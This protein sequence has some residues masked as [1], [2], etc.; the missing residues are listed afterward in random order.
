MADVDIDVVDGLGMDQTVRFDRR[1]FP[2]AIRATS[3]S[4]MVIT[5]ISHLGPNR[6]RRLRIIGHASAGL[7]GVADSRTT[8]D[9]NRL[10]QV[11]SSGTLQ[12]ATILCLLAASFAPDGFVELHGCDVARGYAGKMLLTQLSA[13]WRVRVRGGIGDQDNRPGFEHQAR[14]ATPI[15]GGGMTWR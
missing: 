9:P 8:M 13:M 4:Q 1:E 2:H 15:P 10:I 11:D 6:L 3:V 12:N 14:T 7:Q 5:I